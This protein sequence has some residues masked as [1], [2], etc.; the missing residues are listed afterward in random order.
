MLRL[1][2]GNGEVAI[3]GNGRSLSF[4]ELPPALQD[5]VAEAVR[6][7]RIP[8]SSGSG[9][10]NATELQEAERVGN[11]SHLVLGVA[12]ARAGRAADAAQEFRALQ[13][14]NPDAQLPKQLLAQAEA[15]QAPA[16]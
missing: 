4:R 15:S 10:A 8:L 16:K 7:S 11:G 5:A 9:D 2:D 14:Q 3:G 6:T 1:R 12:K 13:E